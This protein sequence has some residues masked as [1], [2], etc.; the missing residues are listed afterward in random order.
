MGRNL[1]ADS[2]A[3]LHFFRLV[4]CNHE[5]LTIHEQPCVIYYRIGGTE[6]RHIPDCLVKTAPI[7]VLWEIKTRAE[8]LKPDV[9]ARTALL[10]EKLPRFG[11]QYG[12]ALAEDLRRQPRLQNAAFL[13][14]HGRKHLSFAEKEYARVLFS[15]VD[16]LIWDELVAGKHAPFTLQHACRMVLNGEL[17]LDMDQVLGGPAVV[18]YVRPSLL[19]GDING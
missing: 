11:Y 12:V 16:S 18:T 2:P 10:T 7:Q 5:V 9:L 4:E 13:L 1:C 17:T 3:E 19:K 8:S 6:H 14:R 15:T